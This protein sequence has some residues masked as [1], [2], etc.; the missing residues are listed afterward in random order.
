MINVLRALKEKVDNMQEQLVNIIR[1][2]ETLK[3]IKKKY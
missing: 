1:E 2:M 3:S